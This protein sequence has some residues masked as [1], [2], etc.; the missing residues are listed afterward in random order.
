M[1]PLCRKDISEAVS[2]GFLIPAE[3]D[4]P[5]KGFGGALSFA[6]KAGEEGVTIG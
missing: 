5:S 1:R 4:G 2:D 3:A 6:V